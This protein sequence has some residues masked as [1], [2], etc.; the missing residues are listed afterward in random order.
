MRTFSMG[1]LYAVP[2]GANPSVEDL[3][4][5]VNAS[6]AQT[7]YLLPND[8][9]VALAAREVAAL[10]AKTVIVVPTRDPVAGLAVLLRLGALEQP[11][12]GAALAPILAETGSASVFFA[13]K[14]AS[15]E[16]VAVRKGAPAASSGKRLLAGAS[17]EDVVLAAAAEPG[18]AGGGLLTL[19]SGGAQRERDAQQYAAVVGERFPEPAVEYYFGGQSGIAYWLS[20]EQ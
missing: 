17:L 16:G 19:Y 13:G 5:G 8:A 18:A 3:L 6:L 4:I 15:V 7:V 10:T 1:A 12:S 2:A 14:D 11:V 20:F 9:N